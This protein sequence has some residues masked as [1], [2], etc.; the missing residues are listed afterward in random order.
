M[1]K[2]VAAM[3]LSVDG[4]CE[5]PQ[6]FADWVEAWSEDYEL[7]QRIDACLLGSRMYGG[8]EQYWSAI[9]DAPREPLPMT[10]KLPAAAEL[11]WSAFAQRTPHYVLS[12]T[13]V[14]ADW[15]HTT[16][17]RS[18]DQVSALKRQ[19]GK[20]IYLMGGA[21]LTVSLLDAGQVDEFHVIS[22]PLLAGPGKALF[23]QLQQRHQLQLLNLRDLGGGRV[24]M[25]YAI[26]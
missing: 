13:L 19:P 10:G 15:P 16:I 2:L 8:Y 11:A 6:G 5:G 22:Y 4:K 23:G 12:T 7:T 14:A 1:R 26:A 21:T 3:K 17:L 25:A 24:R 20:D 9:R 18:I